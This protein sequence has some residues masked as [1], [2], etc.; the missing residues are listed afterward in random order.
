MNRDGIE[1]T[2]VHEA[3]HTFMAWRLRRPLGPVTVVP[4]LRW[5]GTSH[6]GAPRLTTREHEHIDLNEPYLL[7]PAAARRK[8]DTIAM[9]WAA[10]YEAE[11]ALYRPAPARR[12]GDTLTELA[13]GVAARKPPT[14]AEERLLALARADTANPTD[15][16]HLAALMDLVHPDDPA[17]GSAWLNHITAQ[18]RALA[19]AGAPAVLRL[20]AELADHGSLSGRAARAIL[21]GGR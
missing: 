1:Q 4:G 9:V 14:R 7:W 21:E 13:A 3:G 19:V 20:A 11:Y 6:F 12:V 17:T 2:A 15:E 18:A 8:V 16:E 10:G 5:A